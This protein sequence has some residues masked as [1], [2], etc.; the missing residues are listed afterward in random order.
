LSELMKCKDYRMSASAFIDGDLEPAKSS[1]FN[2]HIRECSDCREYLSDLKQ[3]S[4]AL[5]GVGPIDVPRELRSYVMTSISR[6]ASGRMGIAE[7]AVEY[8]QKLNPQLVSYGVGVLISAILFG[9]TLSGF[10]PIPTF[11]TLEA[12][13]VSMQSIFGSD[14][15]YHSYNELPPDSVAPS[16]QHYYEL[17]RVVEDSSLISFSNVAYRRPGDEEGAVLTDVSPDGRATIVKVLKAANDP[18]VIG[19]LEWSLRKRPFQPALISGKPVPTKI[20][21]VFQKVDITG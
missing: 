15:Q 20:V 8:V 14:E 4:F 5:A 16:N 13:Y 2:A 17:P 11:A 7:R 6:R 19:D 10:K 9:L 12:Q 1:S 18:A 21:L 3:M